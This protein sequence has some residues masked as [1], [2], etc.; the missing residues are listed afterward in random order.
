MKYLL[1]LLF[2][3]TQFTCV[4]QVE[5]YK[6][7]PNGLIYSEATM[8]QLHQIVD[9]LNLKFK[10]CDPWKKYF[11]ESQTRAHYFRIDAGDLKAALQE[12]KSGM[13]YESFLRK[14]PEAEVV[15]NL[16]VLR[17]I[18]QHDSYSQKAGKSYTSFASISFDEFGTLWIESEDTTTAKKE[19]RGKYILQ[20]SEEEQYLKGFY[21]PESFSAPSLPDRYARMVQYVDCMVDTNQTVYFKEAGETGVLDGFFDST[22]KAPAT[23]AFDKLDSLV[24]AAVVEGQKSERDNWLIEINSNNLAKAR[25]DEFARTE[26]FKSQLRQ[27]CQEAKQLKTS[28]RRLEYLADAYGEPET[29]LFLKRSRIVVG[30][31]SQDQ[32]PRLHALEIAKL[33][34][35][36]VNWDIFLRAHLDIMNDNFQR[37]SDGSYAFG[38]RKTYIRELEELGL[39]IE[40]LML[41]LC[42]QITNPSGNHYF[43]SINRI[44]R[45]LAEYKDRTKLEQTM[46]SMISDPTL[47]FNNRINIYFLYRNYQYYRNGETV[48][49]NDP[50]LITAINSFPDY[51]QKQI[52]AAEKH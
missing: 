17:G 37:V 16:I 18:Y 50:A 5:E 9:S 42:L 28:N 49:G 31:C 34:A 52:A 15:E 44:G 23:A 29:A 36:T 19:L 38:Q 33:A 22:Y 27:A 51:L 35:E 39:D 47:D 8:Q 41:G 30:G 11:A 43:G 7:H 12:L 3:T 40:T 48:K 46:A 20:Y 6:V 32:A 45:A 21:F 14:H 13:S 26:K 2:L 4:G 25:L 1:F 10:V 24:E